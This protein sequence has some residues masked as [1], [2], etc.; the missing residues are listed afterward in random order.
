MA[1]D[2][3]D[4]S[5]PLH[6]GMVHWPGNPPVVIER[7]LDIERGDGANVSR[8]S[9]GAHTGTHVDAPLHFITGGTGVHDA[10][11]DAMIGP[12]RLL[13]IKDPRSVTVAEL[14]PYR[15]QPGER[16]LFKT[17]N[18]ARA[19]LSDDF[20]RDFVYVSAT[21]ASYLAALE[22]RT[23]GVDYLSVG[24]FYTDGPETHYALL[25]AGVWIIEGLNFTGVQPGN[26]QLV[27]LPLR[28]TDADGAPARAILRSIAG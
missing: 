23:V 21:A 13:E 18:S 8:L 20:A 15:I 6:T 5:V 14:E 25:S 12:A 1:D 2:W 3:I 24:G 27:C 26:Y 11:F 22:V 9:L 17:R 19:W 16:I 28:I 4:V 7:I 10:P